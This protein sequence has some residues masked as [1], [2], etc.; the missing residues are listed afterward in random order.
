MRHT[1]KLARRA[2]LLAA[3]LTLAGCANMSQTPPGTDINTV[4]QS[5]GQ[6]NTV[7]PLPNGGQR[8][9]WTQQPMGQYA[10]GT[11]VA[12]DGRIDRIT[13]VLTNANFEKLRTGRWTPD[14]L[15]CEFGR[16]AFIDEV[17][18]PSVRQVVWNY[19]YREADS[20]NS[21][22]YVYMGPH[23]DAVTRFHPG[24]D[25]MYEDRDGNWGL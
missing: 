24:P 22:M 9:V 2:A 12:P 25:P 7:C 17:G 23:G 11:N 5:F 6:P 19:R 13:P 4:I 20:W 16:P 1:H 21:L 15:I 8:M 14:Q 3:T 18:M 10:W